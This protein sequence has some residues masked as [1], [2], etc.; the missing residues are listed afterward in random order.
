MEKIKPKEKL[1]YEDFLDWCDED[2]LAEWVDGEIVMYS[3]AS[4]RHQDLSDFLVSIL[5][6]YTE[7][8][9][10][11]IV[12]RSP[13]QMKLPGDLP[14][15]EP[16]LIF[17]S[18][19]NLHR[20]YDTYLDGPADLAVEIIS[21]ES[22]D[23]DRGRKFVEYETAA[24]QEYWLIDP[25]RSQ[26]EFYRFGVDD[27]YH[28]VLPDAE[29]IYH[30]DVVPGFWLQVSWLWQIPLPPSVRILAEIA[31]VPAELI[32]LFEQALR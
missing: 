13:F 30:S 15:R 23:R 31:G 10:L 9:G 14:G 12:R 25:L 20:L 18:N 17:V 7:T 26:A 3:P 24:V 32:E 29:G 19:A 6:I 16:D 8:N 28:V 4:N 22:I 1:S 2:T 5:R 21:K 27:R 11:G